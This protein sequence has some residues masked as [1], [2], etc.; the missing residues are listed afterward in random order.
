[1]LPKEP[2]RSSCKALKQLYVSQS[3]AMII[4]L[5]CSNKHKEGIDDH[6]SLFH[7]DEGISQ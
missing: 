1:M 6:A 7:Q 2:T 5:W 3:K 4:N